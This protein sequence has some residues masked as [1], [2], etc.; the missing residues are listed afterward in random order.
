VDKDVGQ[1]AAIMAASVLLY[2]IVQVP[3]FL[4]ASD[5]PQVGGMGRPKGREGMPSAVPILVV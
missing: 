5:S 3:A 1:G 2:G 4:G